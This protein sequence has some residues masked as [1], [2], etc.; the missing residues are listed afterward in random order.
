MLERNFTLISNKTD[1]EKAYGKP[2]RIDDNGYYNYRMDDS[3]VQVNFTTKPCRRNQYDRGKFNVPANTV[4]D[5][6]VSIKKTILFKDL[7]YDKA[8]DHRD[9]SLVQRLLLR[10][11]AVSELA[12]FGHNVDPEPA[13][14]KVDLL[15]DEH[16]AAC[17]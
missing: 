7:N 1:V 8:F 10:G 9:T 11:D 5:V 12:V 4:L 17:W 15:A 6:W 2:E 13:S 14:P 3:F 16:R